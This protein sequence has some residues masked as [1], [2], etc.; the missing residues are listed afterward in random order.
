MAP[1]VWYLLLAVI[2]VATAALSQQYTGYDFGPDAHRLLKRQTSGP[3]V[4]K[5]LADTD[6]DLPLRQEIRTLEKDSDQ[7]T[8]YLLGLSKMQYT[9]QS[10]PLSW[11]QITGVPLP[12]TPFASLGPL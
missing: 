5:S 6:G 7:W 3:W 2:T 12:F 10:D 1:T 4:L 9:N 11:Y 8:L